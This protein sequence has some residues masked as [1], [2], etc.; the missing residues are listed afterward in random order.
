MWIRSNPNLSVCREN[1]KSSV[2]DQWHFG[3]GIRN[4]DLR[5]RIRFLP[6]SSV[7]DKQPTKNKF[8][9]SFF[10]YYFSKVHLH[11][12]SKIKSQRELKKEEIKVF[13]TFFGLLEVSESV[14]N[15]YGTESGRS[16][17]TRIL[18]IRIRSTEERKPPK[19]NLNIKAVSWIESRR[20]PNYLVW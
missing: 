18:R 7:A 2:M 14:Q 20:I 13:L 10:A 8:L 5:I 6:F 4:T 9:K 16:K 15:N 11:Q 3:T 1:D 17:N 19:M 12:S